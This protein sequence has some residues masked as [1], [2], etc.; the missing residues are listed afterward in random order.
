MIERK[1]KIKAPI[2]IVYQVVRNFQEYPEFLSTTHS[3][4]EKK[5]KTGVQVDFSVTVIKAIHYTLKFE[6]EEPTL[7]AWEFVKG[8]LMKKNSGSW[9]LKSLS[10]NL[11]EAT[12]SIDIDFGWM[13]PKMIIEQV[14][15]IQLPETLDAFKDRAEALAQKSA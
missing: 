3:A 8:D 12:Y 1:I 15:K 7:V 13:V 11:T 2:E 6:L 10:K 5:L 14:T 9:K 4:K